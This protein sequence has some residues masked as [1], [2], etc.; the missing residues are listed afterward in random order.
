MRLATSS[1]RP[2]V[3]ALTLPLV[4]VICRDRSLW[5]DEAMLGYNIVARSYSQLLQPLSYGQVAPIGYVLLSKACNT[6]FGYNDLAIRL[7][8]IV[9]YLCLFVLL[10]HRANRSPQALFR[11]VLIAGAAGVIKYAFELKPY[12]YDVLFMVVVL[13]YGSVIFA[14]TWLAMLFSSA[15]VLFSNATFMQLPL[16]AVLYGLKQ[17]KSPAASLLRVAAALLPLG[18]YY[19]LFVHHHPTADTMRQLWSR[20]FLFATPENGLAFVARRLIGIIHAGY[21]TP[22]FLLLWIPYV[23]GLRWYVRQRMYRTLAAT[24]LPIIVHLAF[25]AARLYPFDGGR[26]TLYLI[27]PIAYVAADGLR[28]AL[29]WLQGMAWRGRSAVLRRNAGGLAAALVVLAVTGNAFAYALLVKNRE[30]IRP[31]FAELQRQPWS[32]KQTVPVHF[33]PSSGAQFAYY[34]A[35]SHSRGEVFLDDYRRI[36]HDDDWEPFLLDALANRRVVLVYSH[37]GWYFGGPK[38]RRG[39]LTAVDHTLVDL[40]PL[41]R[42]G[43]RVTRLMWANNAGLFQVE[44]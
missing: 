15:A 11:F 43:L 20:H 18:V 5:L 39:F 40:A 30:D 1:V 28:L 8:S 36:R 24:Q 6:L 9:A 13:T 33:L 35:Q 22:A 10:A 4:I 32:Y 29:A 34:E 37:S 44:Q 14:T 31:I 16:F 7:P 38:T 19:V 17:A 2:L 27:V 23:I 3:L 41:T 25:S 26:L 21:F 42:H 12:I